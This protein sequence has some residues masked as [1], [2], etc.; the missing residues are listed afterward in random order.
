MYIRIQKGAR[1]FFVFFVRLSVNSMRRA[2]AV[3]YPP[4]DI[5]QVEEPQAER[6]RVLRLVDC[7]MERM[8]M[9][10]AGGVGWGKGDEW[11]GP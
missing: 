9:C 11:S 3:L 5:A 2:T 4:N 6:V 7:G 8:G 1:F 10:G